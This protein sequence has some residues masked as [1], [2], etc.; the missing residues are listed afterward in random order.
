MY[1]LVLLLTLAFWLVYIQDFGG[2]RSP[3]LNVTRMKPSLFVPVAIAFNV[4]VVGGAMAAAPSQ[5]YAPVAQVQAQPAAA[6]TDLPAATATAQATV[7]P[8]TAT[9]VLVAATPTIPTPTAT[10]LPATPTTAPAEAAA[11]SFPDDSA[12]PL[13]SAERAMVA[14]LTGWRDQNFERMTAATQTSWRAR[15][16]NNAKLLAAQ[17]DFKV[18]KGAEIVK[19]TASASSATDITMTVWYDAL[20]NSYKKQIIG[21]VIRENAQG[22]LAERMAT[23]ATWGVNLISMLRETD[24]P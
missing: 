11:R 21:R 7:I 24:K 5:S 12:Y 10:P 20:N 3:I 13:D 8:A 23:G 4:L 15:P 1:W 14:F 18:L 6:A 17:Y 2:L 16:N 22:Q 9:A 19:I